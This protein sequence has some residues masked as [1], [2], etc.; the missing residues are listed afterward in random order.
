[1]QPKPHIKM[2]FLMLSLP[3]KATAEAETNTSMD[4]YRPTLPL[5]TTN[6]SR[7]LDSHRHIINIYHKEETRKSWTGRG[8]Q[9]TDICYNCKLWTLWTFLFI[10]PSTLLYVRIGCEHRVQSVSS[11]WCHAC[12][13]VDKPWAFP[14][15]PRFKKTKQ[16]PAAISVA[17]DDLCM[18]KDSLLFF[19]PGLGAICL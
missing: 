4:W 10:S 7:N 11:F 8:H 13:I 15:A 1:M 14:W 16:M 18:W 17:S 9:L 3:A 5:K 2:A 19:K 12:C 6:Y